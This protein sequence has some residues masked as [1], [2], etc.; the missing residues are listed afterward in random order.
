MQLRFLLASAC[1]PLC[2]VLASC[3]VVSSAEGNEHAA[4]PWGQALTGAE[5][6][7]AFH[8]VRDDA[9]IQDEARTTA[10]NHWYADGRFIN[11]WQNATSSGKVTG[12]WRVLGNKRC[13]LIRSGL[14]GS[15]GKEKCSP[16]Y[17]SGERYVSVNADGSVHAFHKL[18]PLTSAQ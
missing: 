2:L 1:L 11:Q 17:K 5:I 10:V 7:Q 18:T 16:L 8:N 9:D 4:S 3:N 12:S 13:V 15:I 6:R 14:E